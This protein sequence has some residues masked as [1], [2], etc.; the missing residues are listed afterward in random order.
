[1]TCSAGDGDTLGVQ[2][3]GVL[4]R[5]RAELPGL[6]PAERRVAEAVLADPEAVADT[7]ITAMARRCHTSETTV[8]RFCRSIGMSGYPE[9]RLSLARETTRAEREHPGAAALAADI[10]LQDPLDEV[11]AKV[12]YADARGVEDTGRAL[13][14]EAL[15]RAVT[16]VAAARRVDIVGVGASGFVGMDLQ[17]KL[18]RIG[19]VA[20]GWVDT[21]AALTSAALLGPDDVII[22]ISHTGTTVDIVEPVQLATSVGATAV[23]ITNVPGSPLAEVADA[24]L[25]TAARETTFRSGAMASRIAQLAVVDCLFV[26]VAQ[27]TPD[28]MASLE[29]TYQSVRNRRRPVRGR[30]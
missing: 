2:E 9:L 10:D 15:H 11:V 18:H 30:G 16:A 29:K 23:A 26:G 8:L 4:I 28:V 20:F 24:V 27:R 5:I 22:G 6:R 7:P 25:L 1:M 3:P 13:D 17:Q 14:T 12:I 21:H 19:R